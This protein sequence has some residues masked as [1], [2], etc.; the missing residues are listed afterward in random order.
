MRIPWDHTYKRWRGDWEVSEGR[1]A[2]VS[3][4]SIR[5]RAG[6]AAAESGQ[7]CVHLQGDMSQQGE[8]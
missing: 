6:K 1:A 2:S 7:L 4:R 5:N 8:T 3:V